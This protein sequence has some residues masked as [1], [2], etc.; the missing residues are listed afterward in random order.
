MEEKRIIQPNEDFSIFI[1]PSYE[2]DERLVTMLKDMHDRGLTSVIVDDGS[3][4][5]YADFFKRSAAF[6]H[7]LTH[8]VNKGKGCAIRTALTYIQS[9]YEGDFTVV[10]VDSD[11]QHKIEDALNI[12]AYAHDHKDTLVLGSRPLNDDIPFRSRLGNS[13]TRGIY[14]MV[15]HTKVHD[16]Q[17]GLRAFASNLIQT[18]I[19]IEGE[20][21]EYEMNVL[22]YCPY[23]H[24]KIKEITI[25]QIYENNNEGSHYN[26][27]KDSARIFKVILKFV[28]DRKKFKKQ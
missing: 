8:E 10:T 5:D 2:P 27:F 23:M 16:T 22:L 4:P 26:P 11:G 18:M 14:H 6:G 15:S 19:D 3:G 1:V 13:L 9:A 24:L 20:R 21:Y 17:T 7:V 28:R 25:T 12:L